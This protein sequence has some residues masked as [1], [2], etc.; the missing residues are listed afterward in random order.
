[1]DANRIREQTKLFSMINLD[2]DSSLK[3]QLVI[4]V[5]LVGIIM[6]N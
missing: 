2:C 1:M 5:H 6:G 3:L 4:K